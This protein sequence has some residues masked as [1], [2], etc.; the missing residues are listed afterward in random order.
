MLPIL[1]L[2]LILFLLVLCPFRLGSVELA[3]VTLVVIK[4]LGMLMHDVGGNSV[5]ERSVMGSV[6]GIESE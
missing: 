5:E 4:T 2:C 1:Q 3:E 6:G